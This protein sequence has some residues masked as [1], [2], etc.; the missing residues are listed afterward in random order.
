MTIAQ[1][2]AATNS[3]GVVVSKAGTSLV[4]WT[5]GGGHRP[6]ET[7][8]VTK[9]VVA[10]IVGASLC[11]DDR[12]VLDASVATWLPEWKDDERSTINLR[13]LLGHRSGLRSVAPPDI[14]GVADS[15]AA[16]LELPLEGH[17]TEAFVYN[18]LA[19]NVIGLIVQRALGE[20]IADVGERLLF[21]PLGF[22][23]WDWVT[24]AAGNPRCHFG[25]ICR[26]DDL[27]KIGHLYLDRGGV[28]PEWWTQRAI[29]SG[30]SCYPQ[31]AWLRARISS[32]LVDQWKNA[33]IDPELIDAV[34]ALV[35]REMDFDDLFAELKEVLGDEYH[36]LPN[37]ALTRGLR[38]FEATPGPPA[39]YG[40][41][42]DGGQQMI[43]YPELDGVAV[44][45]RENLENGS[46]WS[47]FPGDAREVLERAVH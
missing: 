7:M 32:A 25:L 35:D 19:F 30:M 40:H 8:S 14:V 45:L 46:M 1:R 11:A 39:G 12:A 3:S 15:Y 10:T 16:A 47:A 27:A 22:R 2:A 21:R 26:A 44:R 5:D 20:S 29:A 31:L 9:M 18:N 28:L 4:D 36:A 23:E 33:G 34:A 37:A 13:I 43:V 24:D 42:G 6:I 38:W 17:P 41:D